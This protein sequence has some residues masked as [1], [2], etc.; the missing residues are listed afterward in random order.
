MIKNIP[1]AIIDIPQGEIKYTD[2][3]PLYTI[4]IKQDKKTIY[5]N[6]CYAMVMNMVQSKMKF[7]KDDLS[8]EGDSQVVSVGHPIVQCFALNQLNKKLNSFLK[9]YVAKMGKWVGSPKLQKEVDKV[10]KRNL[11]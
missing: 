3:R 11:I 6:K 10:I 5:H 7:N 1:E 9:P 2:Q 8:V 4:T